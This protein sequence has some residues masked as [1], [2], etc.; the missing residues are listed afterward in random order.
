[1]T[2]DAYAITGG[3]ILKGKVMLSGAKNIALKA[4]IAA[5]MFEGKVVLE[6]VPKISDVLELLHLIRKLGVKAEFN[7]KNT[8]ELDSTGL[9]E[10]RVDLL[11]ASKT[12]V[13]FMLFAP[14]LHRFKKCFIPN[15]G[16]CRIGARPIDR[17]TE[18]MEKL[19]A[20]IVYNHDTGYYE[21]YLENSVHGTYQFGKPSHTGTELLIMFSVF[22]NGEIILKN[23]ALEPEIDELIKFLNMGGAEIRRDGKNIR[24]RG[25]D[26]LRQVKPFTIIPDSNEAATFAVL[27]IASR[28]EV[29]IENPPP[30]THL[31]EFIEKLKETG[32]GVRHLDDNTLKFTY[33][34]KIKP[35]SIET[36]PHPGFKTDWQPS[37]AVLMTQAKGISYI[38]EKVFES[39]FSYVAE[40]QKLG[41]QVSF[42]TVKVDNPEEFYEFYY[43]KNK[44]YQQKIKIVGGHPLHGGALHI[45][46]L[47]AGASVAIAALIA[48]GGSVVNGAS[49]LE[50][51]Y[52]EFIEKVQSLGGKIR[53][54]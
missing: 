39:R 3:N 33:Q 31:S 12:R 6:S 22:G 53:K 9:T 21:A 46:D 47:R 2:E 25:V 36:A 42:E 15:P 48:E 4:I 11:H 40:L 17:I 29:I 14:L 54:I 23:A 27:A 5:L 10:N 26:K 52:E 20:L 41:A 34:G 38:H 37:W 51:G 30:L 50:R 16:G 8:L 19:G 13:S 32:S 44:G 28:G 1:M 24:I 49:I 45:W 35:I 7:E 43:E 18:G